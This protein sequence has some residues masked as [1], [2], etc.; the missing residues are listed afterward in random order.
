L[1]SRFTQIKTNLCL[2][3]PDLP[4]SLSTHLAQI[5]GVGFQLST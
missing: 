3:Y 2:H 4:I 1:D 5:E